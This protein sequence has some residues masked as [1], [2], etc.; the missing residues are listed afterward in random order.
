VVS[1]VAVE[2]SRRRSADLLEVVQRD[3]QLGGGA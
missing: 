1:S 2:T 3:R